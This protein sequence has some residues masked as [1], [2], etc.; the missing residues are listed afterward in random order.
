MPTQAATF[1]T[2]TFTRQKNGVRNETVGLGCSGHARLCPVYALVTRVLQLRSMGATDDTSINAFR[3]TPSSPWTYILA[4]DLTARIR[5]TLQLHPDPT[6]ALTDVSVRS[7]R[8]GG[9][10]ALLC[11]GVPGERIR[12]LGRWRS[13]EMFRYLHV[14]AQP[15][16]TGLAPA[17]LRGGNFR[18]TPG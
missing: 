4:S 18:L 13:D 1:V 6:Y 9:A 15:L 12:L 14:Q 2:L 16:M 8:A 5:A 11:A 17:L 7:T 10:N 3:A